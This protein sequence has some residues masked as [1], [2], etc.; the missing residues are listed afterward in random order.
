MKI[1]LHKFSFYRVFLF[2]IIFWIFSNIVFIQVTNSHT[3]IFVII[4][5]FI[6]ALFSLYNIFKDKKPFSINK[7]Y[8]YFCFIFFFIAPYVQYIGNYNVWGTRF[9]ID[10]TYYLKTNLCII[11][12][13]FI[14][15]ISYKSGYNIEYHT[16]DKERVSLFFKMILLIISLVCLAILVKNVGFMNLFSRSTNSTEL[17]ENSMFN[18]IF[19]CFVKAVPVYCFTI[20]FYKTKKIDLFQI[21]I[22]IVILLLNF[23]T[24]TTRFWMG[25]IFIGIILLVYINNNKRNRIYDII[26]LTIFTIIFPITYSFKFNSFD[27]IMSEG[28]EM[29]KVTESYKSVDYDAYSVLA[30]S[31]QYV[32]NNGIVY[33]KQIVGTLLFFVPRSIWSNKPQA[34]GAFIA[35]QQHQAFTNISCPLPAEGFVNFGILGLVIFELI[36]ASISSKLDRMYWGN[37]QNEYISIVYPYLVGLALFYQRGALHHAVVYTFCFCLPL[38]IYYFMKVIFRKENRNVYK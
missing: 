21:F 11:L 16:H 35:E 19:T 27:K 1:D 8:W 33:G 34:T 2:F 20:L 24:S 22:L 25:A 3:N 6:I 15:F 7:T 36:I 17:S 32:D 29:V 4:T 9:M 12:G 5:F 18:T 30:R 26:L 28:V 38:I 37:K 31:I 10:N 23:P 13:S 14:H